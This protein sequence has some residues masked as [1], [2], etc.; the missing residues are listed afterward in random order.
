[1]DWEKSIICGGSCDLKYPAK[2]LQ[3]N[4]P[5]V[6]ETF[7]NIFHEFS[8][9]GELPTPVTYDISQLKST[10][11]FENSAKWHKACHLKFAQTKLNKKMR[12]VAEREVPEVGTTKKPRRSEDPKQVCIFCQQKDGKL[13]ECTTFQID[14]NIRDMAAVLQDTALFGRLCG[15]DV[16]A[17]ES[18]YHLDCLTAFRNRYRSKVRSDRNKPSNEEKQLLE[19]RCF[20]E[21]VSHI[22]DRLDEGQYNFPLQ[23]LHTVYESRRR[24][25]G[26]ESDV[27]R[28]RLKDKLLSHFQSHCQEQISGRNRM[29]V[30]TD[31][32]GD[33]LKEV[34]DNPDRNALKMMQ[35]AK[36]VRKVILT[37]MTIH[38]M[39][40]F[41]L[42]VNRTVSRGQ[43]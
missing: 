26:V 28:T 17:M 34:T 39:V 22:H 2:S 31:G 43:C 37:R 3:G 25:L 24:D 35:V 27:N 32:L 7:I 29:L 21:L 33:L 11:L 13:H 16:I 42:N 40:L 19:A 4:A 20:A 15:S 14:Q 5:A 38:S 8:A 30:F 41:P 9:L 18:K 6:Y 23:D 10:D 12:Q 36:E 1:M